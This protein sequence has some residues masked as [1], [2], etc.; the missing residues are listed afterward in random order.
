MID[1]ILSDLFSPFCALAREAKGDRWLILH[2]LP[3]PVLTCEVNGWYW[4]SRA[5]VGDK[6]MVGSRGRRPS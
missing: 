2:H 5:R 6:W 4:W 1:L 3:I